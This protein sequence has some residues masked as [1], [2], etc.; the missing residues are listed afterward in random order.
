MIL[1]S[2]LFKFTGKSY[3]KNC[4]CKDA[5]DLILAV[6]INQYI[7]FQIYKKVMHFKENQFLQ[8]IYN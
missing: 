6:Y 3:K 1:P 7:R 4:P 5:D 8:D 2:R